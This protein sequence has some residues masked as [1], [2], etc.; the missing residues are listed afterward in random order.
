MPRNLKND[1][2]SILGQCNVE[3]ALCPGLQGLSCSKVAGFEDGLFINFSRATF[4]VFMF[5]QMVDVYL[6]YLA[7]KQI[8]WKSAVCVC[9]PKVRSCWLFCDQGLLHQTFQFSIWQI[10]LLLMVRFG[11][12]RSRKFPFQ[13]A[14]NLSN[15]LNTLKMFSNGQKVHPDI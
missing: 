6:S 15:I 11:D 9:A 13:K 8:W 4:F 12:D 14:R 5:T 10:F 1:R 2:M 7:M 3:T